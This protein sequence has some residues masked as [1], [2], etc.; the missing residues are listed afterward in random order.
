MGAI[1]SIFPLYTVSLGPLYHKILSPPLYGDFKDSFDNLVY[2]HVLLKLLL[3]VMFRLTTS[4]FTGEDL[5]T[6]AE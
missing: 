2:S 6:P 3:F 1:T 5:A 4:F